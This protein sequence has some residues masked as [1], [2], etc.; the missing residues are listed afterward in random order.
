MCTIPMTEQVYLLLLVLHKEIQAILLYPGVS[1]SSYKT[2][3]C[4]LKI[5]NIC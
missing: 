3:K 5:E 4:T 2:T 1:R